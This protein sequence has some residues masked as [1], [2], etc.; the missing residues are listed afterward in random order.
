[1][2]GPDHLRFV[3][4]LLI[5]SRR[6]REIVLAASAFT[7]AYSVTFLFG[8]VVLV[9]VPAGIVEPLIALSIAGVA[10][11]HLIGRSAPVS[12]SSGCGCRAFSRSG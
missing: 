1:V 3:L 2:V 12:G 4:A 9:D 5:G 6:R 7:A 11:L 8:A 10:L